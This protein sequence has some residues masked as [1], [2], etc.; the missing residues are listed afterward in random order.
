MKKSIFILLTLV[1]CFV[2]CE[3]QRPE[4][5]VGTDTLTVGEE[6]FI[7]VKHPRVYD[8]TFTLLHAEDSICTLSDR[9]KKTIIVHANKV[10]IDTIQVDYV[11]SQSIYAYGE[12]KYIPITVLP[13]E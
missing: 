6:T 9:T 11:Y 12:F 1:A 3:Y 5:I 4:I 13:K 2:S 8:I 10:G 7:E